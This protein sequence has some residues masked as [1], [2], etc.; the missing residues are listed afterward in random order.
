MTQ[1]GYANPNI[2][3]D[4]ARSSVTT[5]HFAKL[6]KSK[7]IYYKPVWIAVGFEGVV[8]SEIT[9]VAAVA[10]VSVA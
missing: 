8:V 4:R 1:V 6:R 9:T 2:Y 7:Y 3:T 10:L 5:F